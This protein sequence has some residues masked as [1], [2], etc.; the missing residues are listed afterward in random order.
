MSSYPIEIDIN[1]EYFMG[2]GQFFFNI[3]LVMWL[4][5]QEIPLRE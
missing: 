5:K 1:V 4:C 3:A 2:G